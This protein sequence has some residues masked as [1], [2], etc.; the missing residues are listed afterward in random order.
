VSACLGV[1]QLA[2]RPLNLSGSLGDPSAY[3]CAVIYDTAA[4]A[5]VDDVIRGDQQ[6]SEAYAQ[7]ATRLVAR[8]ATAVMANCGFAF[9]YGPSMRSAVTVP[10]GSSPLELLD[11]LAADLEPGQ[12]ITVLTF[13]ARQLPMDRLR[14]LAS[15]Q[16]LDNVNVIGLE[17]TPAFEALRQPEPVVDL[18]VLRQSVASV[19]G[20]LD[21]T[22]AALLVECSA[23]CPL[24]AE[25]RRQWSA[26]VVDYFSLVESLMGLRR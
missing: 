19:L 26:P 5:W 6:L 9:A 11:P 1:I 12:P 23:V 17:S 13:D 18:T 22:G 21:T 24:T 14:S 2:N 15:E 8:G 20:G 3:P 10:V 7:A 4:N 25:L 16:T